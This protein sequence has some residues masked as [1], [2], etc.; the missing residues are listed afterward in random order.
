[1]ALRLR[2]THALGV[3]AVGL[4]VAAV[5]GEYAHVWRRGRAPLPS[6]A[7]DVPEAAREAALETAEVMVAGYRAG[8]AHENALLNLLLSYSVTAALVRASTHAIRARGTFGPFRD[9]RVGDRHIH[10]FL[11]GIG[12]AFVTGATSIVKRGDEIDRWLAIPFGVGAALTMDE[13]ALLVELEDVYW[14]KEGILSVQ[15]TLGA[16]TLLGALVVGGRLA[17]RGEAEVLDGH[18][19]SPAR[20]LASRPSD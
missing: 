20:P 1:M 18:R 3:A 14:S 5:V 13:A 8:S 9:L 4:T 10:H 6:E 15:A 19:Q 2:S 7:V 11:P 17:R 12:L 16:M